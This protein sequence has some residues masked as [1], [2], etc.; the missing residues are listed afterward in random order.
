MFSTVESEDSLILRCWKSEKEAK[1]PVA[2]PKHLAREEL[3][4]R[5]AP[6][7]ERLNRLAGLLAASEQSPVVVEVWQYGFDAKTGKLVA[8]K[9]DEARDAPE[10][11]R[12]TP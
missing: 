2:V 5:V 4:A 12:G 9:R 8:K 11:N 3:C 1:I 6:T 7:S 10:T